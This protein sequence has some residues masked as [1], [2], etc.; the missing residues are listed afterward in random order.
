MWAYSLHVKNTSMAKLIFA[1]KGLS[2]EFK[3]RNAEPEVVEGAIWLFFRI[4]P[5]NKSIRSM[6]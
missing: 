5:T 3:I 2:E 6:H 4:S 1:Q